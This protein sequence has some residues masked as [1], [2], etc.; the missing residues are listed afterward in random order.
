MTHLE[1]NMPTFNSKPSTFVGQWI[2]V[3]DRVMLWQNNSIVTG[4]VYHP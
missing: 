3:N 1:Q 4:Y 2:I